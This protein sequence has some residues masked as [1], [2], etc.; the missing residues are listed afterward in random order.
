MSEEKVRVTHEE[1]VTER[2]KFQFPTQ[3]FKALTLNGVTTVACSP[4]GNMICQNC[5]SSYLR[6]S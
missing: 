5:R 1:I 3:T 2:R 6:K 4:N